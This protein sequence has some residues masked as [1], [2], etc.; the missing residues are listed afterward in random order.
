VPQPFYALCAS[1]NRLVFDVEN[2]VQINEKPL[3]ICNG[4]LGL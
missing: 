1:G 3:D 2:T 4:S